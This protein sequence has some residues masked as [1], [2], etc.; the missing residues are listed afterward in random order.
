MVNNFNS[1]TISIVFQMFIVEWVLLW[2]S[3]FHNHKAMLMQLHQSNGTSETGLQ[4]WEWSFIKFK[5]A[6]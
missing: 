5:L 1:I 6:H 3:I 4:K 2:E